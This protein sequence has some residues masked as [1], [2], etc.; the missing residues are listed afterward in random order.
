VQRWA[1][2]AHWQV[3]PMGGGMAYVRVLWVASGGHSQREQAETQRDRTTERKSHGERESRHKHR[4]GGESRNVFVRVGMERSRYSRLGYRSIPTVLICCASMLLRYSA[5][6]ALLLLTSTRGS[7]CCCKETCRKTN[8]LMFVHIRLLTFDY[9]TVTPLPCH[10]RVKCSYV[11]CILCT[12]SV[13]VHT[14]HT[15]HRVTTCINCLLPC[16]AFGR[17]CV[18]CIRVWVVDNYPWCDHLR[19]SRDYA[20][21]CHPKPLQSHPLRGEPARAALGPAVPVPVPVGV[22]RAVLARRSAGCTCACRRTCRS[23]CVPCWCCRTG[24]ARCSARQGLLA[25]SL[26]RGLGG[27]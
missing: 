13:L 5:C 8:Y 25:G 22:A 16:V 24:A 10:V 20:C 6:D 4:E 14:L 17:L 9:I 19:P 3:R 1:D 27:W 11:L 12:L 18:T 15:A 2:S 21:S 26:R 23:P 7:I